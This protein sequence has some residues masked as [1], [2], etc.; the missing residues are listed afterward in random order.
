MELM[1]TDVCSTQYNPGKI[2]VLLLG[3]EFDLVTTT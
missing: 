3:K 2:P 1:E